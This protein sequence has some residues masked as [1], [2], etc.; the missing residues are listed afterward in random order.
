MAQAKMVKG[1]D[2]GSLKKGD[3]INTEFTYEKMGVGKFKDEQ[4]YITKKKDE[5]N[6]KEAGRGDR[7]EESWKAD[8]G[9]RFEPSFND[10]FSKNSGLNAG[11]RPNAKYTL[12]VN[13]DFT[14]PGFNVGVWRS[15]AFI[16]GTA[17]L[18]ETA[19]RD[20]VLAE[21]TFKKMPG[22]DVS[23]YDFDT[24]ERIEE[25]YAKT[26]KELGK[27]FKKELKK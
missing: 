26:G 14:E 6:K 3:E 24:G 19:N 11:K 8:R 4:D 1:N 17:K 7:W 18:V 2:V 15:N 5:Y 16:N 25:A 20:K 13:T 12:I 9:N 23:G 22:R 21:F 10:L 27:L